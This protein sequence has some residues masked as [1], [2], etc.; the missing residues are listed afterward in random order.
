MRLTQLTP[1][2]REL[3]MN[4]IRDQAKQIQELMAKLEASN[5]HEAALSSSD[6]QSPRSPSSSVQP[7]PLG[8]NAETVVVNP[9]LQDWIAKA[10]ESLQAFGGLL[11]SGAPMDHGED[12]YSDDDLTAEEYSD[13]ESGYAT[14]DDEAPKDMA[15]PASSTTKKQAGAKTKLSLLPGDDAPYG[16]MAAL[17][18]KKNAREKSVEP[19]SSEAV[20]VANANFFRSSMC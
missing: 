8:T 17:A 4:Q 11:H 20:G 5:R 1:R 3:L 18:I 13:A 9:E 7:C 16:L 14:A 12:P 6:A 10:Q 19:E 15:S 2:K